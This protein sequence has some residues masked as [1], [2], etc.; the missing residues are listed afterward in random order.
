MAG[1]LVVC[2]SRQGILVGWISSSVWSIMYIKAIRSPAA[3]LAITG[4]PIP[5][6]EDDPDAIFNFT[7]TIQSHASVQPSADSSGPEAAVD[8]QPAA[9]PAQQDSPKPR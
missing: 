1:D 4:R 2:M 5:R 3:Y 8:T 7:S 6:R 9:P